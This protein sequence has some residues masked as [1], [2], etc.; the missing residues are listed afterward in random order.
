MLV[1]GLE[2]D[3]QLLRNPDRVETLFF[4]ILNLCFELVLGARL[5][6]FTA[7]D[8]SFAPFGQLSDRMT[9]LAHMRLHRLTPG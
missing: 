8:S 1:H 5:F 3:V 9:W 2:R 4:E 6:D 7:F